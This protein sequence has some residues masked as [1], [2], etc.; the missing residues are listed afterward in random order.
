[1]LMA[2]IA[3]MD[4]VLGDIVANGPVNRFKLWDPEGTIVYSDEHRLIGMQFAFAQTG[5]T[6]KRALQNDVS[7]GDVFLRGHRTPGW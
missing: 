2:A 5:D 7:H 4:E 6:H 1:M 3:D